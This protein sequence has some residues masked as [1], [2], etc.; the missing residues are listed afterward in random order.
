[1]GWP[2]N[3]QWSFFEVHEG[4]MSKT[5]N[6]ICRPNTGLKEDVGAGIFTWL[7]APRA[8]LQHWMVS[9]NEK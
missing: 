5:S 9:L 6:K 4:C 2:Q 3:K 8:S 1:M 7:D